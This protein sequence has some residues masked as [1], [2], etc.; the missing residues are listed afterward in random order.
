MKRIIKRKPYLL[1]YSWDYKHE[2]Y[3][4]KVKNINKAIDIYAAMKNSKTKKVICWYVDQYGDRLQIDL[5]ILYT[6]KINNL[7]N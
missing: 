5:D 1:M 3:H 2:T 6:L 7:W 4:I